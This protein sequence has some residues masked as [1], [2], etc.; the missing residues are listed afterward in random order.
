MRGVIGNSGMAWN[1][2]LV[3]VPDACGK[4]A[5]CQLKNKASTSAGISHAITSAVEAWPFLKT[6]NCRI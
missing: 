6:F 5:K 1:E 3:V 4:A 2:V